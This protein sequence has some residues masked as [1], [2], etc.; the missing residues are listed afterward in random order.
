MVAGR[1]P[2]RRVTGWLGQRPIRAAAVIGW[3][4]SGRRGMAGGDG[5]VV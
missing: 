1:Y 2:G 3:Q 5:A 4:P